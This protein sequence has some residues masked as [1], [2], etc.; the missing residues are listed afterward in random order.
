M[1]LGSAVQTAV[2]G[3]AFCGKIYR[4]RGTPQVWS[5]DSTLRSPY[6]RGAVAVTHLA[7]AV[8]HRCDRGLRM[9]QSPETTG[10]LAVTPLPFTGYHRCSRRLR[11][12]YSRDTTRAVAFYVRC[13]RGTPRMI[14]RERPSIELDT[15][16]ELEG[17]N[18]RYVG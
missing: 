16:G 9:V 17:L 12:V 13:G 18:I 8:H 10:V 1:P 11:K 2:D 6:T 3:I 4:A 7:I 15:S 5:R 14:S